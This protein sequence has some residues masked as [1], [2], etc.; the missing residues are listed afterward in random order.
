MIPQ[1]ELN[2]TSSSTLS[3]TYRTFGKNSSMILDKEEVM[4]EA[5]AR[6][7]KIHDSTRKSPED[8][9]LSHDKE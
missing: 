6:Y 3:A 1:R 5:G 7:Y 2:K 9:Y 8:V 4:V